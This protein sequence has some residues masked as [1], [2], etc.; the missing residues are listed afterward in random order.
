MT[1]ISSNVDGE[2][3]LNEL[4]HRRMGHLHHGA[5]RMLKE[6]V[7]EVPVLTTKHDDTCRR[8]MLGKYAKATYSRS[9]K[10]AKSVLEFIHSD[11]CNPMSI[12]AFSGVEYFVTFIDDH[13]RKTWIYFL[14]T[15]DEVFDR[16]KE[17]KALVENLTERKIKILCSDNGGEYM[18]KNFTNFCAREGIRREW[19]TPYNPEQNGVT[20]RKNKTIVGGAKAMLYDQNLPNFLWAE[21]CSATLHIQNRTPH[22]AL[23][24]KTPEGVFMGRKPKVT[25][26]YVKV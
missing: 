10:R 25:S 12:R 13:S 9:N 14:R 26:G 4:W 19:T 21:A 2:K 17:F 3:E 23:G 16:F 15:K 1:L 22:K 20:E 18:D 6:T 7:T 11:I 8:C 5:L 24:K